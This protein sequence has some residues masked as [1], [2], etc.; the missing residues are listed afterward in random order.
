MLYLKRN[1]P[2]WERALRLCLAVFMG[3]GVHYFLVKGLLQILLYISVAMLVGT[4]F[5]GFC[6]VCAMWGRK[7]EGLKK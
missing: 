3:I 4:A 2:I 7:V 1:L 6:P 5:I